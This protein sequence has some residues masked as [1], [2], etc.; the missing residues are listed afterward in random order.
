MGAVRRCTPTLRSSLAGFVLQVNLSIG[1]TV[2]YDNGTCGR[3]ARQRHLGVHVRQCYLR[4][5]HVGQR[6]VGELVRERP[7]AEP[8]Y[9]LFVDWRARRDRR[10]R[11]RPPTPPA[12]RRSRACTSAARVARRRAVP[13]SRRQRHGDAP[14]GAAG[15]T[16][17]PRA[18]GKSGAPTAAPTAAASSSA[19]CSSRRSA[20]TSGRRATGRCATRN[21]TRSIRS[22]TRTTTSRRRRS[23]TRCADTPTDHRAARELPRAMHGDVPLRRP[24]RPQPALY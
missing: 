15:G 19:T 1:K 23:R 3:H 22:G 4:Q 9:F 8:V 18:V 14:R 6:H 10:R 20:P 2:A 11:R 21:S 24:R 5:R 13:R 16:D 7:V 17:D 12:T